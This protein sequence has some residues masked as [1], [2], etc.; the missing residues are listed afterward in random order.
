MSIELERFIDEKVAESRMPGLACAVVIRDE[1][2]WS[3]GSG[4]ADIENRVPMQSGT[5]MN[6]ASVSKT[7][8]ATALLR[9]WKE[10]NFGLDADVESFLG[11]EVRNPHHP[12]APITVRQLLTH[13]SS[14]K[15]G[16]A[17][18]AGYVCGPPEVSLEQWL[19]DYLLPGG[20]SYSAGENF[21]TCCGFLR[22]VDIVTYQ[23]PA[24]SK[25]LYP[26]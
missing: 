5:L 19:R 23:L 8:T 7:V 9:L 22:P 12:E 3:Y 18:D 6:V 4:W 25:A 15:D 17:Y 2:A 20:V 11:F 26:L 10:T 24:V 21:H 1:V 14:I 13:R 16:P